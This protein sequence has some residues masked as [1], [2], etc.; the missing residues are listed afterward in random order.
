MLSILMPA[1][2]AEKYLPDTLKSL[3][4]E[5]KDDFEIVICD[6]GSTDGTAKIAQMFASRDTRV[7]DIRQPNRG[8][9]AARNAAFLA[10]HGRWVMYV[11]ADDVMLPGSIGAM[12][13]TARSHPN[14]IVFCRWC[15]ISS[16]ADIRTPASTLLMRDMAG[17]EWLE[18]AFS[19][20]YPTY[21]GCFL[22]PR[23]LIERAGGWNEQLSFQDDMEFYA[24]VI[25][26]T[27]SMRYCS[28]A[29]FCS[30]QG[31]IGSLSNASGRRSSE[32]QWEAT[33]L[34]IQYLLNAKDTPQTR[35]AA[36]RQLMLVS[37]AQYIAAPDISKNAEDFARKLAAGPFWGPRL[38]GGPM[39]LAL[40]VVF[41]WKFALK[42]HGA[43]KSLIH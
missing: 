1:F 42:I 14:E 34:A 24:R 41:G 22:L 27:S 16:D 40:Q 4:E 15:K 43:L 38:P 7:R 5:N 20:D 12:M 39:R 11:D 13:T 21:P 6:D 3:L 9:S 30:R 35:S 26:Q 8:A 29:L 17:W 10:S 31:V 33:R 28:G 19:F 18:Q 2:N 23:E 37:Y 32:S 36:V 25:S